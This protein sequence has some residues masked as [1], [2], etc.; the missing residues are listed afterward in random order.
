MTDPA[1]A[2]RVWR[3][4]ARCTFTLLAVGD[5]V[6]QDLARPI[7]GATVPTILRRRATRLIGLGWLAHRAAQASGPPVPRLQPLSPDTWPDWP[8]PA[9][10]LDPS[11]ERVA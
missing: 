8:L 2:E 5:A 10:L 1:R 7:G 6:E 4:M 9:A 3:P 11:A